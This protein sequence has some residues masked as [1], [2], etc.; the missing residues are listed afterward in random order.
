MCSISV[1]YFRI[2]QQIVA[3]RRLI[4]SDSDVNAIEFFPIDVEQCDWARCQ[5][6]LMDI[7]RQVFIDEQ[8][9]PEAE[10]FGEEED[11]AIHWI[12]YGADNVVMGT[13]RLLGDKVGR[14]AVLKAH[15]KQGVG[16]ALMRQII[17]YAAAINIDS[18]QLDAQVQALS[19]YEGMKFEVDGPVFDDVGIPHQ[20]MTLALKHFSSPHVAP[21]PIDISE[22]ER[23]HISLDS[24]EDFRNQV[25]IL[26]QRTHRQ[27]RIFSP[28]LDPNIFDNEE[29]RTSLFNFASQ[30]PYAEINILIQNPHLLVQ[31]S[32]RLLHLYHRL[33]S[34]VQMR[35]LKPH[36]KTSH[37]EFVLTDQAGILYK[38]SLNRYTG[39][40]VYWSPLDATEL[41]NDFD[42]LWNASEPDPELRNLPM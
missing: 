30:H 21:T 40:A 1:L 9:V 20:H 25:N 14:M 17:R 13:A 6:V 8:G 39:Y 19:F 27:I 7:R 5:Q 18:I 4:V 28:S 10:E 36:S 16:S 41:A 2:T 29:L 11:K 32:H 37:I 3:I 31:N 38:Q 12:A 15:R 42:S 34:R 22:E 23:R 35:T 33:S 26:V 24:V